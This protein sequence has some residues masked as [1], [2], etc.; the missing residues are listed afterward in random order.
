MV[1]F[2][3][4]AFEN[5]NKNQKWADENTMSKTISFWSRVLDKFT[6]R[7]PYKILT[8]QFKSAKQNSMEL[9]L[10]FRLRIFQPEH[11]RHVS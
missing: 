10:A 2:I 4:S 7:W 1:P 5:A 6:N 8:L 3:P 11:L 9:K